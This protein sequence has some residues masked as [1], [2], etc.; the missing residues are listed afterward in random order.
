MKKKIKILLIMLLVIIVL[1]IAVYIFIGNY[2]Y[3]LA[4]NPASSKSTVLSGASSEEEAQNSKKT[5]E[6]SIEWLEENSTDINMISKDNLNLHAYE[7]DNKET[8][9]HKWVI[10]V[11]GYMGEGIDMVP[12][13]KEFYNMGYNVLILDLKSHGKSQGNIIGMG[14]QDRIDVI[15]WINKIVEKDKESE[16]ILYGV[17]MGAATVMMTTGEE[18]PSNV[19]LAIEDCGYTNIWDEFTWVLKRNFGLSDF[20]VMYAANTVTKIKT[21]HSLKEGSSTEAVKKSKTPTLF[22]HGSSDD[23][24]PFHM[25]DELYNNANCKKEKLIIEGADHA[26]S[27]SKNPELYWSTIK[28]FIKN[29]LIN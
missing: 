26:G 27:R 28:Q 17:S 23:F 7:I 4:L 13:S 16:I 25:L 10:A 18:L 21:G 6:E 22:I 11:H 29:N 8:V 15:D 19:K 12:A 24:V 2:F 9:S 1:L 14:W 5:R 20:P 3:D